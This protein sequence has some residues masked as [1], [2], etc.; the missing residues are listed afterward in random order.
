MKSTVLDV[1]VG[2]ATVLLSTLSYLLGSP[3]LAV[4]S[5]VVG[6]VSFGIILGARGRDWAPVPN[7]PEVI[8]NRALSEK[9]HESRSDAGTTQNGSDGTRTRDLRRD[10]PAL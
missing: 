7:Q 3:T 6:S 5:L 2:G 1:F 10:R 8:G 9:N 4:L